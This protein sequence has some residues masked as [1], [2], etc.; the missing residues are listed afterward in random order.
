ML[1]DV[2][3]VW[4]FQGSTSYAW[5]IIRPDLIV[6]LLQFSFLLM[7]HVSAVKHFIVKFL[8]SYRHYFWNLEKV[9]LRQPRRRSLRQGHLELFWS[10]SRLTESIFRTSTYHQWN[11]AL[12]YSFISVRCSHYS[13][14][15]RKRDNSCVPLEQDFVLPSRQS[16]DQVEGHVL[17]YNPRIG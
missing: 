9:L 15:I 8:S 12:F 11:E 1:Y 17:W 14:C 4:Y 3:F 16:R 2:R 7:V 13:S 5:P 10:P 6:H